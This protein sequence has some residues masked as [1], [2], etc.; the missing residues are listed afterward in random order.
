MAP[1]VRNADLFSLL[2]PNNIDFYSVK[3]NIVYIP[4]ELQKWHGLL[5]DN[6]YFAASICGI[7]GQDNLDEVDFVINRLGL[8]KYKKATW[9]EISGG[10]KMRFSLAKALI[11]H[12][13]LIILDEPLANLDISTQLLFL[14]DIRDLANSSANPISIIISS[15]HLYEVENIA[16]NILFLKDGKAIYNGLVKNFGEDRNE[17]SYEVACELTYAEQINFYFNY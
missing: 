11:C 3:Q 4:Q 5:A 9:G 12:P 16:D 1:L 14:Q 15:Q 2:A 10:F 7:K 17:N 8:E 13:K 6:L